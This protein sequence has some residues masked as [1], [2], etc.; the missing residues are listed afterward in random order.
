[1]GDHKGVT[2]RLLPIT[3]YYLMAKCYVIS[4]YKINDFSCPSLG[5]TLSAY[6]MHA[7]SGFSR[8]RLKVM[9]SFYTFAQYLTFRGLVGKE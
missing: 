4:L 2:D 1:M 7:V 6:S 3:T 8:F 9:P 5:L